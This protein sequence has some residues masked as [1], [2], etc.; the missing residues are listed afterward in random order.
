MKDIIQSLKN[1]HA[2][3]EAQLPTIQNRINTIIKS[4]SRDSKEIE[5]LLD[6]L[7]N[8]QFMGIG[9]AE[10]KTLNSYYGTFDKQASKDWLRIQKELLKP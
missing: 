3:A 10:F 2:L 9:K 4:K 1:V 8:Y 6:I 5:D 7:L